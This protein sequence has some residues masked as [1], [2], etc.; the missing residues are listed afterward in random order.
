MWEFLGFLYQLPD[1]GWVI[2][3]DLRIESWEVKVWDVRIMLETPVSKAAVSS[4]P[5]SVTW[6][7]VV[8]PCDR[9]PLEYVVAMEAGTCGTGPSLTSSATP[10]AG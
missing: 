5:Q 1:E 3:A 6:T 9:Q 10:D 4:R 2:P 7:A 8:I